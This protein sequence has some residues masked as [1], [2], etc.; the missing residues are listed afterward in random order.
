MRFIQSAYLIMPGKS[1]HRR[2]QYDEGTVKVSPRVH[3]DASK[4][5][6]RVSKSET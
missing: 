6:L 3:G 1:N 4:V 5:L 2:Y